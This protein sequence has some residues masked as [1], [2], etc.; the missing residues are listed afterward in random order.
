M[1]PAIPIT[2]AH[3][4]NGLKP[5]STTNI[6]SKHAI[7]QVTL[8]IERSIPP[9]IMTN[10]N[11][12]RKNPE[13]R[14]PTRD[15]VEVVASDKAII[16]DRR[17]KTHENQEAE[18][19][20]NL[21]HDLSSTHCA[22]GFDRNT[23]GKVHDVLLANFVPRQFTRDFCLRASPTSDRSSRSPLPFRWKRTE[24]ATPSDASFSINR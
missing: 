4:D 10:A 13:Q 9:V 22:F 2:I 14:T 3:A 24:I 21:I 19:S 5:A 7:R 20:Q 8:P 12:D 16:H 1:P 23:G 18:Y 17:E 6:G 11:S 15:V